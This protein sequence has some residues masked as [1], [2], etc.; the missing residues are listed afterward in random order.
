MFFVSHIWSRQWAPNVCACVAPVVGAAVPIHGAIMATFFVKEMSEEFK[1]RIREKIM[2]NIVM[3]GPDG[4]WVWRGYIDKY[5]YGRLKVAH[6]SR[7][8]RVSIRPHRFMAFLSHGDTL[9]EWQCCSHLCHDTLCVQ[10]KHVVVEPIATNNQRN[11]CV[12]AGRCLGHSGAPVCIFW[13]Q[14]KNIIILTVS[15]RPVQVL[16]YVWAR[17]LVCIL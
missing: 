14:Y 4:C 13:Y 11:V 7:P 3:E 16:D 10:T 12:Q 5:G 1:E 8:G 9:Y 2:R 15:G 17:D 6:H